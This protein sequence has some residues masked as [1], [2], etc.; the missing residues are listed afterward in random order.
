MFG[1][2]F[3]S[4]CAERMAFVNGFMKLSASE[5]DCGQSGVIFWCSMPF[6]TSWTCDLWRVD[7]CHCLELSECRELQK[8]DLSKVWWWQ[9][10]LIGRYPPW[11]IWNKHQ[12]LQAGILLLRTDRRSQCLVYA[13]ESEGVVTSVEEQ[14]SC[15]GCLLGVVVGKFESSSS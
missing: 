12:S 2:C 14:D 13:M 5:F 3:P 15:P 4:A 1:H 10:V 11:E 6:S 8:C 7:R 9:Q